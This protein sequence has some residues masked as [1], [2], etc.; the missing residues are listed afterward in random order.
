MPS[1]NPRIPFALESDTP[2]LPPFRGKRVIVNIAINVEHW[3][4][5][6]PMP[7]A[8]LPP[9]HGA[10]GPVPDVP[11]FAWVEYGLR[12]GMPRLMALCRDLGAPASALTNATIC[13]H[14]PRLAEA[15][16]A[17]GWEFV[18]HGFDQ[19]ALARVS[20]DA[21]WVGESLAIMRRFS[22]QPVRAW[23]GPGMSEKPDTPEVLKRHGIAYLHDWLVDDVPCWMTTAEGPLLALPYTV[24]LNDVPVYVVQNGASAALA[25]RIRDTLAFFARDGFARTRV[26]TVALH[27]HVIGVAHRMHSFCAA[28][29]ALAAHPEVA[30]STSSGIGA[31]FE[32]LVPP[33]G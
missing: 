30:F 7:R 24:E 12:V 10:Q 13:T 4:F 3:P 9:P 31:W 11:N 8:I 28:M 29:E 18:G 5:D 6:R 22:G 15:M 27:P 25:E 26:M 17:T 19:Q 23:L 1:P 14:Y 2:P 33:P 16:L 32:G 21:A 20:D